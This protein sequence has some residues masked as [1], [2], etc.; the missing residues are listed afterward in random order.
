MLASE[1]NSIRDIYINAGSLASSAYIHD[2]FSKNSAQLSEAG[3]YYPDFSD[4]F[5][6]YFP[7]QRAAYSLI[8]AALSSPQTLDKYLDP[9]RNLSLSKT[10]PAAAQKLLISCPSLFRYQQVIPDLQNAL[11]SLFPNAAIHYFASFCHQAY[12]ISALTSLR[13]I[14]A[15]NNPDSAANDYIRNP[16]VLN[17]Y[18]NLLLLW[19]AGFKDKFHIHLSRVKAENY[20]LLGKEALHE[21]LKFMNLDPNALPAT[22]DTSPPAWLLPFVPR[23][24]FALMDQVNGSLKNSPNKTENNQNI[25]NWGS[26]LPNLMNN[27]DELSPILDEQK[28]VEINNLF[29][30][31]N[32]KLCSILNEPAFDNPAPPKI[33]DNCGLTRKKV[34]ALMEN[35][36]DDFK[37]ELRKAIEN[38][39]RPDS[40]EIMFVKE[41]CA[42]LTERR[43][44]DGNSAFS[45]DVLTLAYNQEKYIAECIESVL[46][47]KTDFP[48][49]HLIV[50]DA[51]TDKTANI[52]AEYAKTYPDRIVPIYLQKNSQGKGNNVNTLF[53]MCDARYA[54][55]CDG[56]DYFTDPLKLQK[57]ADFLEKHPDCALCFHPVSVV[58]ED[59]SP[60]RVYPPENLLP[61]G[62]HSFYSLKDLLQFNMIQTNSVM[63]RWRFQDG[64][65]SWFVPALVPG[66]W[67]WHLLHAEKGLIAYLP[68]NMASY[69]RHPASLYATAESDHVLHRAKHGLKELRFYD[70]VDRHFQGQYHADLQNLANGVFADWVKIFSESDDDSL[71]QAGVKEFPL[72]AHQFLS[73]LKALQDS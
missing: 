73:E 55:L 53:K 40:A 33:M 36:D 66:D 42:N 21:F 3:I 49:R 38:L 44:G 39:K 2:F 51:S 41:V 57:Q 34:K 70:I 7:G 5:D 11:L 14:A 60:T 32:E 68:D 25:L 22:L 45:V 24:Y 72:F 13:V 43:P 10:D 6:K 65:P 29:R 69:R 4:K 12:E 64:L 30:K 71:L 67:Y 16:G 18:S 15:N 9:L 27:L 47:Q 59:G 31:S 26:Q 19:E 54:A 46:A 35:M 20:K 23:E 56:D 48:V 28:Y 50:D 52:I 17:Y 63:Y 8:N 61:G 62:V 58:Y 1:K 37:N